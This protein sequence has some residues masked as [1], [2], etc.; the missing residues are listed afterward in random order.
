MTDEEIT[1]GR[2]GSDQ[3]PRTRNIL[4]KRGILRP[5]E[6]K[7][8]GAFESYEAHSVNLAVWLFSAL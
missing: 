6:R 5:G 8:K 1:V 4:R 2:K 7:F 3:G